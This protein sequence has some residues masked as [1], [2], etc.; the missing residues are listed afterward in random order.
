MWFVG[1]KLRSSDLMAVTPHPHPHPDPDP[2]P[3][4]SVLAQTLMHA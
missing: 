1:L 3:L 2:H 4:S